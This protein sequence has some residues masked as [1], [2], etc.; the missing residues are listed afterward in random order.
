MR[1][2]SS[3]S[4]IDKPI[5]DAVQERPG[6]PLRIRLQPAILRRVDG[7]KAG[8]YQAWRQLHWLVEL[9]TLD[10]ARAFRESLAAFFQLIDE[11]G[12]GAV[13]QRLLPKTVATVGAVV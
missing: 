9:D 6:A 5:E 8:H 4:P 13:H 2:I 10:D 11:E 1:V 12:I 7:A 3:V